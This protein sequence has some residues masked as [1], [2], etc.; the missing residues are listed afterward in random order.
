MP[1][2]YQQQLD[3]A[4]RK[5][6][7]LQGKTT[8][9]LAQEER[10]GEPKPEE[11]FIPRPGYESPEEKQIR[12]GMEGLDVTPPTEEEEKG[13]KEHYTGLA[14]AQIDAINKIYAGLI[15]REEKAGEERLGQTRAMGARAGLLGSPMGAAQMARTE[16]LTAESI[17]AVQAEQDYKIQTILGRVDER[18]EAE[19][20]RRKDESTANME[21]Y[22]N[23]LK[24]NLEENKA[25]YAGL[26]ESGVTLARMKVNK[27]YYEQ[28]LEEV[29]MS[30][31]SFDLWYESRMPKTQQSDYS[32]IQYEK[33]GNM[34]LKRIAF[35]PDTG[36]KKEYNYDL[37]LPWPAVATQ[38]KHVQLDD[39]TVI[40]IPEDF[41]PSKPLSEQIIQYGAKGKFAKPEEL[42][43]KEAKAGM[44]T[45]LMTVRGND[46]YVSSDDYKKAKDAW[47]K[48]G[49][50]KDKFDE[51]FEM[52]ANPSHIKDYE[53]VEY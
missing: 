33:N 7:E 30:E 22:M 39:G 15:T 36:T 17:K 49:Y 52:F 19:I 2:T 12:E 10:A 20:R 8:R 26:A 51:H 24:T 3:E 16:K 25:D 37:G 18:T 21:N 5:A 1:L 53:I 31:F 4:K 50:S 13:L 9:L 40:F 35:D 47:F 38:Y 23:Y 28:A 6:E 48:A 44:K 41:D 42:T 45:Q 11:P 34:W 46:G 14:Q 29:G 32:E 27:D 43:E